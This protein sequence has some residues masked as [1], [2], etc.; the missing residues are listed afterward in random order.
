MSLK[1]MDGLKSENI[2]PH[3]N[4]LPEHHEFEQMDGLK[5]SFPIPTNPETLYCTK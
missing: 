3:P 1:Q 2:F 5:S 4:Q